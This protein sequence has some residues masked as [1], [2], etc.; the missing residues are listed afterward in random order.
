MAEYRTTFTVGAPPDEVIAYVAD[1]ENLPHWD[2]SVR[3]AS[4]TV[5]PGPSGGR[6]FDVVVG[7]YGRQL[8]ATY[9]IIAVD[10]NRY[11]EWTIEG[12]ASG[13][14]RI[15]VAAQGP[16][17]TIDYR[18]ELSMNGIARMLDRGLTVALEGIGENAERGLRRTFGR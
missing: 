6:A 17:S 2:S 3:Q 5:D 8:A 12:K 16:G 7:F 11:V 13:T 15:D 18:V 10:P 14:T 9:Q 1:L 4:L